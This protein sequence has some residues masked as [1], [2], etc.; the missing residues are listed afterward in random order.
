VTFLEKL[1]AST[2]TR[3]SLLCIGLDPELTRLPGH[4][5]KT[6]E[7]FARFNREII[8]ATS[9]LVSSYKPNL[10]FYVA[11]GPDG[12]AAL[13]TTV[14]SIPSDVVI[15]GDAKRGD[16]GNT[17]RAYASALFDWYGF[18]AVT[19]S[20]YLGL[21]AVEPFLSYGDRGTLI[22]C[23][24]SNPGA[25]EIQGLSV[26]QNG[27]EQPLYQ[28]VAGLARSWNTRGNVGL[29]V[30][31]TAPA[32]LVQI[33]EIAPDLP[34]LIPAIGTQGGDLNAAVRAHRADA[35][36]MLSSSRSIIYASDG[37]DFAAAARQAALELRDAIRVAQTN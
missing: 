26:A 2:A 20:P 31:A 13:K 15:L 34:I 6:A 18:D 11:L 19:I 1:R 4:L 3:S 22:L 8:E 25:G 21:D 23:R 36:V 27:Q 29:V 12:L 7:G 24:T 33:R 9:D 5:P 16:I 28:V 32:E 30:G 37:R 10:A 35:P 14:N 17:A